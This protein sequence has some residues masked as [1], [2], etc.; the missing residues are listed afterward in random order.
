MLFL[1]YIPKG[2][3]I[4]YYELQIDDNYRAIA[5]VIKDFLRLVHI[6]TIENSILLAIV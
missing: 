6:A 5:I 4:K 3:D 2:R 1:I